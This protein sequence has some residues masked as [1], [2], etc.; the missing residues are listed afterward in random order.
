MSLWWKD[1]A[2]YQMTI[3]LDPR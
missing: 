2:G 3:L 1:H